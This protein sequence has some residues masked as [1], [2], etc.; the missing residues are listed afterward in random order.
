MLRLIMIFIFLT[1]SISLSAKPKVIVFTDINIGGGDPD[2]RQ[3]LIHPC[4]TWNN[5]EAMYAYNKSTL[6]M[7][8]PEMY[9]SLIEKLEEIYK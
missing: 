7:E 1:I 3:S 2:D 6:E 9:N 5:L 4:K 8:R